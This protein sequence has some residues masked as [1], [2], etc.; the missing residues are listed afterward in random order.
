MCA[1]SLSR[2]MPTIVIRDRFAVVHMYS[3]GLYSL[4]R[5][6]HSFYQISAIVSPQADETMEQVVPAQPKVGH[7]T[8]HYPPLPATR[9]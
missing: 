4:S 7:I 6:T 5:I 1:G 9:E 8:P 3:S 2:A